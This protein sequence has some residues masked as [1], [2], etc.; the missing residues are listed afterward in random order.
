MLEGHRETLQQVR[1]TRATRR[2]NLR[3]AFRVRDAAK[4]RLAG[5]HVLL[6][7]DFLTTGATAEA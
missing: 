6:A 3:G 7:D 4:A 5:R 1:L 2:T